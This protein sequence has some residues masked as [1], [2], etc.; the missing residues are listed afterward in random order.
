MT[1]HTG[2]RTQAERTSASDKAMLDAGVRLI[3]AQGSA[4]T[5]LVQIGKESGFSGGLVSDRFGSKNGFLLAVAQHILDQW[6]ERMS[7]PANSRRDGLDYLERHT[8]M[9]LK[10]VLSQSELLVAQYRLMNE[11]YSGQ[12]ELRPF[13]QKFDKQVRRA[14]VEGLTQGVEAGDIDA[15]IDLDAF[16]AIF[17]GMLRGLA[18][19]HFINR[20]SFNAESTR[21]TMAQMFDRFFKP[22]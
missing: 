9:Y 11:S 16:S 22:S 13:F 10:A 8:G 4:R 5:T 7:Q 14:V 6:T 21:A 1:G 18:V 17:V 20:R 2:R 19:Q 12:E 3:A 15:A